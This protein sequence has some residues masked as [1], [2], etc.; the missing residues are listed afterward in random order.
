MSRLRFIFLPEFNHVSLDN[1]LQLYLNDGINDRIV[2]PAPVYAIVDRIPR[3]YTRM[4]ELGG[5]FR[6]LDGGRQRCAQC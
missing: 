1:L 5:G 2:V 6:K 4:K 3:V